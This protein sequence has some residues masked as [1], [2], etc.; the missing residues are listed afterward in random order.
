MAAGGGRRGHSL[1]NHNPAERMIE[2]VAVH[3][4][5]PRTVG[6]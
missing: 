6:L 5:E 4:V 1:G 3:G 2:M